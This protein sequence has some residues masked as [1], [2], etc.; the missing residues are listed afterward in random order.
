MIWKFKVIL[1]ALSSSYEEFHAKPKSKRFLKEIDSLLDPLDPESINY[2]VHVSLTDKYVFVETPKVACSSIKLSLINMELRSGGH[3]IGNDEFNHDRSQFPLLQPSQVPGFDRVL[4]SKE[5]FKFCFVRNPYTRILAG[6]L[7]KILKNSIEKR[8][9]LIQLGYNRFKLDRHLSF[10]EFIEALSKQPFVE[11]D[12]HWREQ[13]MHCYT[14]RIDYDFVGHLE[15]M[16]DDL[17][18]VFDRI[19]P[20]GSRFLARHDVHKTSASSRLGEFF[21]PETLKKVNE[22]YH[23][24]FET[25]GYPILEEVP[26]DLAELKQ[27]L[28]PQRSSGPISVRSQLQ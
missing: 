1:Q 16:R 21:T 22:K 17:K 4:A 14:D 3:S 11:Q 8:G 26:D 12:P 9:I 7:D 25:F 5:F 23:R 20:D 6:Y 15:S 18:T 24:D 27:A 10:E 19:L 28:R 2:S 13:F